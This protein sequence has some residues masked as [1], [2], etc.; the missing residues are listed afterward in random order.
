M[1]LNLNSDI[2]KNAIT[3]K[4][5]AISRLSQY[6]CV[7]MIIRKG[8]I[9]LRFFVVSR[10]RTVNASGKE[11]VAIKRIRKNARQYG[12]RMIYLKY[13][14]VSV[15]LCIFAKNN[16]EFCLRKKIFKSRKRS[17]YERMRD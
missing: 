17:G 10:F 7:K 5:R 14:D 4:S 3:Y 15:K 11:G 9:L 13:T 12:V 16:I 1:I 6:F 2:K 8:V